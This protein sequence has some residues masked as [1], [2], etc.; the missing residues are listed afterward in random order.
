[1]QELFKGT[2][3]WNALNVIPFLGLDVACEGGWGINTNH[4]LNPMVYT[5]GYGFFSNAVVGITR[6][7]AITHPLFTPFR[8]E[9]DNM[10]ST[11]MF[12]IADANYG[13]N[14]RAKFLGD[15]IPA[16]SFAVGANS[17]DGLIDN[18]N[19]QSAVQDNAWPNEQVVNGERKWFHSDIRKVAYFYL[20]Q[21]FTRIKRGN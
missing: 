21:V 20:H 14:L 9:A 17:I 7:D 8:E 10:H 19:M 18:Y 2:S 11:N 4:A 3:I 5:P 13:R 6:E 1:M 16:R 15:A 12:I